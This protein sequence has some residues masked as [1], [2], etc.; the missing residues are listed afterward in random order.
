MDHNTDKFF[1]RLVGDHR[2]EPGSQA[3]EKIE[4]NLAKKNRVVI[5]WRVAAVVAVAAVALWWL[6]RPDVSEPTLSRTIETPVEQPKAETTVRAEKTEV[7]QRVELPVKKQTK[8]PA[9]VVESPTIQ[10]EQQT[11]EQPT[12]AETFGADA[13]V[14]VETVIDTQEPTAVAVNEVKPM[15]LVYEL[16]A[17]A[18]ATTDV[19]VAE[20]PAEEKQSPLAKAWAVAKDTKNGEGLFAELDKV[21]H[22]LFARNQKTTKQETLN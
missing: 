8:K 2:L 17:L 15:V 16:P 10:A 1:E 21:K 12:V 9:A 6:V 20:P 3:W 13:A 18:D 11:N 22:N 19:A 7:A 14:P 4:T 5:W